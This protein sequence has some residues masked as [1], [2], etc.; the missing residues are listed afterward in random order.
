MVN[1]AEPYTDVQ[2]MELRAHV[3]LAAQTLAKLWPMR[4]FISRNPLQGMEHLKFEEAVL[5]G[6]QLFGGRGYLPL[7]HYREAFK[8]GRVRPCDIEE[9][10]RPLASDKQVQFGDRRLSHVDVLRIALI[11]GLHLTPVDGLPE[12]ASHAGKEPRLDMDRTIRWLSAIE[13]TH[14]PASDQV[15][16]QA[17]LE[18][19]LSQETL[20]TWCDRTLGTTITHQINRQMIK[21]CAAFCDEGEA[22]W[23]MPCRTEGFYRAWKAAARFDLSLACLR[24]TRA[25]EKIQALSDRPED[26]LIESLQ[27]LKV[28]QTMWQEYFVLHLC[29]LPGWTGF[30]KWRAEQTS[31][32]WQQLYPIDLVE[33]LA[34]RLFYERVLVARSCQMA[35]A[36]SGDIESVREYA[37][38]FPH[39]VWFWRTLRSGL[40][41]YQAQREA[42]RLRRWW[43][44]ADLRSWDELAQR[45]VET[46]HRLWREHLIADRARLIVRLTEAV[47]TTTELAMTT[48]PS[49][50]LTLLEWLRAFPPRLQALKWLEASELTHQSRVLG[51][52]AKAGIGHSTGSS[53]IQWTD[54]P[55][56]QWV[57][58]I[59][60]RSEVLRR[61]LEQCGG[62]QTLG[63]AGFF[64]LPIRYQSMDQ[65]HE[66]ELCPVLLRAKHVIREVPRAYHGERV[67][68]RKRMTR[69]ATLWREIAHD[70]K[71]NVITPYVMVEAVGWFYALPLFAKTLCPLVHGHLKQRLSRYLMPEVATTLTVDK[72]RREEAEAIVA[73]EQRLRI[74]RWLRRRFC[75]GHGKLTTL[76]L[77]R[78]RQEAL[79]S[80]PETA[81]GSGSLAQLLDLPPDCERA[82]REEIRRDCGVSP[83]LFRARFDRITQTGFTAMEQAYY[84]EAAL[85]MMGL[86]GL[87]A[88]LVVLCGHGSTTENNPYESALDCGACGGSTGLPN[89]RAFAM[90]ANRRQIREI[91]AQRGLVIPPDTHF[92]AAL[93][94]TTTDRLQIVDLEDV[95]STHR[96]ELEQILEDVEEARGAA[97]AERLTRLFQGSPCDDAQT[98]LRTLERCS[99]DWAE[100]RPEWGLARNSVFIVGRRHLTHGIDLEGRAFLHSYDVRLDPDGKLLEIILTAPLIVAQ[101]INLEYYFSTVD[102]AVYGSGSKVYHNVTGRI[103]VMTG[104]FSDLRMGLP[105][106]TVME[107]GHPY[108]EPLRLVAVIEAP[109]ER[110]SAIIAR[111]PALKTLCDNS[112]LKLVALDPTEGRFYRYHPRLQWMIIPQNRLHGPS[113]QHVAQTVMDGKT[114]HGGH[115]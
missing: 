84:V 32:P 50:L 13:T 41:P 30:I 4:T 71:H 96:K 85:R 106:Q 83:G 68:Q 6:E 63:F 111:Q 9:V 93:H 52:I 105:V 28:P 114:E 98:A 27:R 74:A 66:A 39:V 1:I 35:L 21:W 109:P 24:I 64:G 104:N 29:A 90:I 92:V 88:R 49:D 91:L 81:T 56:A 3:N 26:T 100:V 86:A 12:I 108:H 57:F 10:L 2:R 75:M 20:A 19:W 16:R 53:A 34:V 22:V 94:D 110:I 59:D 82:M 69:L 60:V 99:L 15:V 31:H 79:A 107:S 5:R 33:Y 18:D 77:E 51:K 46:Y 11:H 37:M 80:E 115:G 78:L 25:P 95:P 70:L 113:P 89:A 76:V 97:A 17:A 7:D 54:R 58:C 36:C 62:Y 44:R 40:L 42:D 65:V 47:G 45:W 55:L 43:R 61:H 8:Q 14:V 48:S 103:G 87:F 67:Q 72:L 102:P 38:R 101:W 112:W 23:P 73:A